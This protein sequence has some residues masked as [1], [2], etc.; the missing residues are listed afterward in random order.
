MMRRLSIPSFIGTAGRI[1]GTGI[2]VAFAC[3]F[4]LVGVLAL[5]SSGKPNP[6]RD[7]NGAPVAGSISEKTF[8]KI[9]GVV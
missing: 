8:V 9:N 7:E 2:A 3:L 4:I 6:I 5:R 1:M